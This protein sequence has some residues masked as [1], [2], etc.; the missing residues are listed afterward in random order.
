VSSID[1]VIDDLKADPLHGL[2]TAEATAR[3]ILYGRNELEKIG[4]VHPMKILLHQ[5]ANA[6]TMVWRIVFVF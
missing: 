4:G 5:V 1:T 2:T 6:M 3:L